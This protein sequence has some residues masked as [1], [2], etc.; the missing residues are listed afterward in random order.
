[1]AHFALG[2]LRR[3]HLPESSQKSLGDS[4]KPPTTIYEQAGFVMVS[5][6]ERCYELQP[7]DLESRIP[8]KDSHRRRQEH[9][10]HLARVFRLSRTHQPT[11]HPKRVKKLAIIFRIGILAGV[12]CKPIIGNSSMRVCLLDTLERSRLSPQAI[13]SDFIFLT[14]KL[15]GQ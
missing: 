5:S 15:L 14:K 9:K 1:M 2:R 4:I 12:F 3:R 11:Q 10:C 6:A 7:F 8:G 13:N